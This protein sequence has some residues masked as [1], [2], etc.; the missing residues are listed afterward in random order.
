MATPVK[1]F[2]GEAKT[3]APIATLGTLNINIDSWFGVNNG[4][5]IFMLV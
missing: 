5:S 4:M 3:E 2:S 1:E